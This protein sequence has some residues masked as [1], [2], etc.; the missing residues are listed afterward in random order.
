M[1]YREFRV[2][3]IISSF[4]IGGVAVVFTLDMGQRNDPLSHDEVTFFKSCKFNLQKDSEPDYAVRIMKKDLQRLQEP[5]VLRAHFPVV[6]GVTDA[7]AGQEC[8]P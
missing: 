7:A 3:C 6:P 8:P 5:A 2:F 4:N 1:S